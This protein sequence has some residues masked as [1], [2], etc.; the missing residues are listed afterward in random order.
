MKVLAISS[1]PRKGGNSEV[2]CDQ[3]LKGSKEAGFETEKV[4]LYDYKINPCFACYG[5][6]KDKKCV[7]KDDMDDLLEKM[8]EADVIVLSTPIY[9]YSLCAQMKMFIDRC[10]PRYMEI[11]NKKFY[12]IV[13]CA[14]PNHNAIEET[15]ADLRGFLKCLP[16]AKE[17][18]MI[19]G[20]SAWNK[21]DIYHLDVMNT[22]YEMGKKLRSI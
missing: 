19:E 9:F 6:K 14:D 13:T 12:F 15:V 16:G 8:I 3:F 22:A 21:G 7:Q 11:K 5:C 4:C 10:L 17:C 20:T 1:S 18:G 2:L